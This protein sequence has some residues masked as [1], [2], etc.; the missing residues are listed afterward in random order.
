[1]RSGGL[2]A[3]TNLRCT[4]LLPRCCREGLG[5]S[6][7]L[8]SRSL[9]ISEVRRPC[10]PLLLLASY[11]GLMAPMPS[12]CSALDDPFISTATP[13]AA[14]AA[15]FHAQSSDVQS[16]L[17]IGDMSVRTVR[18]KSPS[19]FAELSRQQLTATHIA[20]SWAATNG[21]QVTLGCRFLYGLIKCSWQ[22]NNTTEEYASKFSSHSLAGNSSLLRINLR[23][24]SRV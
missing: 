7:P 16:F 5:W 13:S 3:I 1:M 22:R 24:S 12:V 17:S 15:A 18:T 23:H 6:L 11:S 8:A 19:V 20:C 10:S 14:A 4:P 9:L 2:F 21:S